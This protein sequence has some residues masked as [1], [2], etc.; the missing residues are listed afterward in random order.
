[1]CHLCPAHTM[2]N[3]I[4]TF[5]FQCLLI[6]VTQV[7]SP[8]LRKESSLGGHGHEYLANGHGDKYPESLF[9]YLMNK[10]IIIYLK[11][12]TVILVPPPNPAR[13]SV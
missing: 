7:C 8:V 9:E 10:T 5:V 6:L 12:T 13:V 2:H 1:M 3:I 4:L 11:M